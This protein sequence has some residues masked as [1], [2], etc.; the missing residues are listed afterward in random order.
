M[1]DKICTAKYQNK[2]VKI[3]IDEKSKKIAKKSNKKHKIIKKHLLFFLDKCILFKAK[4][5]HIGCSC[6]QI[7]GWSET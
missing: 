1:L 3:F 2:G 6:C 5:H 4:T 7:T